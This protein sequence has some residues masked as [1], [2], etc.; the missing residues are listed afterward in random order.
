M[1]LMATRRAV[2]AQ[3][4]RD[5]RDGRPGEL[6][7]LR[8]GAVLTDGYASALL[9]AGVN[10]VYVEDDASRG[11]EV[12]PALT[13]STRA[14]AVAE[15]A[16]AFARVPAAFERGEPLGRETVASVE[17][18]VQLIVAE[19]VA[20]D[21][22]VLALSDLATADAYTLQHSIDVTVV[23]LLIAQRLL[24]G[25]SAFDGFEGALVRLGVGLLL[26]DVGKLGVPQSVLTKPGP[27]DD[28]EWELM[29]QHPLLG[30][31]L[32][33][34]D[35]VSYH[36]KAVIR[37]HHE[38]WDGSGYPE[39]LPG[40]KIPQFARIAGVAD[41]FDAMTSE[42]PYR[43]AVPAA[44]A[45]ATIVDAAGRKFCPEVVD[46]FRQVVAPYPPGTEVVLADG[47]RAIV[48]DVQP[49]FLDRP[50]V[51]VIADAAGEPVAPTD[52]RLRDEPALA[53]A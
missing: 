42:R 18:V 23:G 12:T 40:E 24:T 43:G 53:I 32:I 15:L 44:T 38:R 30:T 48:A 3:L 45:H 35:L 33:R 47:R 29:R 19:L 22:C 17:L 5:V 31:E 26:H 27:L 34:S 49:G 20:A 16:K 41:V 8:A 37:S 11:I 28:G 52:V 51:R 46:A 9:R 7:L 39:G 4:A 21:D 25:D 36:A 10:A 13:E 2:G 14:M 1:R 6:P 50:T